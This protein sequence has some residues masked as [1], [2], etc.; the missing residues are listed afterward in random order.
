VLLAEPYFLALAYFIIGLILGSVLHRGDFCTAGIL[1]DIF[2]FR[3]Y[4]LLRPLLLAVVLTMFLFLLARLAGFLPFAPPPSY[5]SM[6][7]LLGVAG[8]LLF[9]VGMVLAGGCVV[10]TLYKMG[11]GN[12]TSFIAF[13]GIIAGSLVYAEFHPL[14][15]KAA[16]FAVLTNEV[17]LFQK[18]P[19]AGTVIGWSLVLGS[20]PF[21]LKWYRQGR[22]VVNSV[23]EGYL[24]PWRVAVVL[25]VLNLLAYL[26]SGMPIGISTAFAKLGAFMAVLVAPEHVNQLAYFREPSLAVPTAGVILTGGAGPWADLIFYTEMHLL[27]GIVVGAFLSALVLREFR[28]YGLPPARQAAAAFGGGMLIALGARMAGGCNVKFVLG[29]LPLLS[30]QA[31]LFVGGMLAGAWLGSLLLAGII[32]RPSALSGS[33]NR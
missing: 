5:G 25:A 32:L 22:M 29:G 18:W 31:M 28:I 30:F 8:G 6:V 19:L 17:T 9:G 1:R 24:Q 13:M 10:G 20:I 26:A 27:V 2:L 7:T 21:F 33:S 3:D 23:A 14:I 11:A 16:G 15:R 4:T 12:L